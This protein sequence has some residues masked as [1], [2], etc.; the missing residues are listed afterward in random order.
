MFLSI[1][2]N[3]SGEEYI[4]RLGPNA[5]LDLREYV[6]QWVAQISDGELVPSFSEPGA[7][8]HSGCGEYEAEIRRT[9][10]GGAACWTREPFFLESADE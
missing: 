9:K 1:Y 6:R 8:I 3:Q 2:H 5:S 4:R 7:H 10:E